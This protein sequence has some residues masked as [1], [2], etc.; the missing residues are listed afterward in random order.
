MKEP[1]KF[2]TD[3]RNVD[4]GEASLFARGTSAVDFVCPV[5]G[6]VGEIPDE[7]DDLSF[8]DRGG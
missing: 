1:R 4:T 8:H 7:S 5:E 6:S 3:I 2:F